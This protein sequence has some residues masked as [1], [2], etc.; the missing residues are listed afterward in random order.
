MSKYI[1]QIVYDI[2]N[3]PETWKR[4][5]DNELSKWDIKIRKLWNGSKLFFYWFTSIVEVK[6][7]WICSNMD[8]LTISDKANIEETFRWWIRNSDLSIISNK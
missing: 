6:I 2:R 8:D 3:N 7:N 1:D 5:Y 4:T